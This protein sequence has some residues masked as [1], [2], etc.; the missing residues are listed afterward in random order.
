MSMASL[1]RILEAAR[2][3]ATDDGSGDVVYALFLEPGQKTHSILERVLNF[4]IEKLQPPPAMA[5]VE[6]VV[7]RAPG[8]SAPVNFATYIGD[9]AAWRADRR[10]NED[11]YLLQHANSWRAVPVFRAQA[12]RLTRQ[13]CDASEGVEYSLSR[14]V[15]SAWGFRALSHLLPSGPRAPAHCATITARLLRAGAGCAL[16]QND[17]YYGPASL[18]RALQAALAAQRV[19]PADTLL[20]DESISAVE[21][22]LRGSDDVVRGIGDSQCVTAIRALTLKAAA[23]ACTGEQSVQTL[24]Q[25]QLATALLRWAVLS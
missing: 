10:E 17:A 7:P 23:A 21:S 15:T 16:P 8:S 18:Y 14:Y 22:L 2:L 19:S 9:T 25:K 24:T 20:A 5:H 1:D 6:L 4:A 13:R 11:F 12:A 3:A